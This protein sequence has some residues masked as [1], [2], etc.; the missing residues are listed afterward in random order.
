MNSITPN[1]RSVRI[2]DVAR[3]AGVSVATVSRVLNAADKVNPATQ[4]RVLDAIRELGYRPNLLASNLRRQKTRTLGVVI[5]DI[6][7]P[8]YTEMVRVVEDAAYAGGFRVLLCNTDGSAEKQRSYLRLLSDERTSG[9]VI[10]ASDPD[11]PEIAH[12]LDLGIPV[13][14]FDRPVA[15]PRAHA[16][17]S[18]NFAA[19]AAATRHLIDNGYTSIGLVG[20]P[21]HLFTGQQRN[22]GYLAAMEAGGL[23]PRVARGDFRIDGGRRAA[24]ELLTRD[25]GVDALVLANNLTSIGALEVI[26]EEGLRVPDDIALVA[27]DDPFWTMVVTPRLTTLAQPVREMARAAAACVSEPQSEPR[28]VV[29]DFELRVRQSC[30]RRKETTP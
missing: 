28:R 6:E 23:A 19:G 24:R 1:T 4:E 9:V 8:H 16:V 11:D 22:A 15:D 27:L 20:G 21:E 14:A 25:A 26:Q 17:L 10:A 13:V 3:A 18:D 5:S 12:L 29:Y 2:K 30:P 7:N